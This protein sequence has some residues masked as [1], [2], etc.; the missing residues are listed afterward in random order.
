VISKKVR[1]VSLWVLGSLLTTTALAS[2]KVTE[3]ADEIRYDIQ[4]DK[5]SLSKAMIENQEFE[6]A[7]LM[8]VEGHEGILYKEGF[9]EV[10]VVRLLV[11]GIPEVQS[12]AVGKAVLRL[13]KPLMPSQPS[14]PKIQGAK[15][16][17]TLNRAVYKSNVAWPR[18]EYSVEQAGSV[19]GQKQYLLT[20][21]PFSY[22]PAIQTYQLRKHY[23]VIVKKTD[24]AENSKV[25]APEGIVFVV[26][27][28]FASSP[29]LARYAQLK[30]SL[31]FHVDY[32]VVGRDAQTPEEIRA[33]LQELYAR[34]SVKLSYAIL[35]GDA[36]DVPSKNATNISGVTDH[37]YSAIDTADYETDINGPDIGVGRISAIDEAQLAS[38]LDKYTRYQRGVF[39]N[40]EWLNGGAFLATDDRYQVAEGTHNYAIENYTA[41]AGYVGIFPQAR[42]LG[43]DQLYAITHHVPNETVQSAL[44]QGRTLIDYSGH[45]ATTFWAGP[46][47]SQ[48]NVRAIQNPDALP[49]VISNACI[50]GQFTVDES[51][52]ETWQRHPQ[53]AI[54]F[55]GSMDST[56]WDE[57]DI[58]ERRMFDTIYRDGE[59]VFSQITDKSL[60][61]VWQFYGGEGRSKYYWETYH[62]F[63]D[64]SIRYR[65]HATESLR[66]EGP[67]AL[68]FGVNQV[69]YRILNSA[70]APIKGARAA[71]A[72][73]DGSF[74]QSAYSDENGRVDFILSESVIPGTKVEVSVEANNSRI[75]KAE[76]LVVT[77][78]S[79]YVTLRNVKVNGR[80]ENAVYV[81]ETAAINFQ[82]RNLG[83]RATRGGTI[84][85]TSVEGPATIAGN[86]V[87]FG[88]IDSNRDTESEVV[89]LGITVG[90]GA[91][92]FEPIQVHYHWRTV[93]GAEGDTVQSLVVAKGV[94]AVTKLDF[95]T[96]NT[97]DGEGIRAGETGSV[98]VTIKNIGNET[99]AGGTLEAIAGS[100]VASVQGS[101]LEV[102]QLAPGASARI[103]VAL[104]VT[105]ATN[106]ANGS[107]A[108]LILRGSYDSIAQRVAL[109]GEG[110]F[111]V[112]VLGRV[113]I[114]ANNLNLT[115]PDNAPALS[116]TLKIEKAGSVTDVGLTVN[117]TH[118]YVSDLV[119]S[120]V[121]PDGTVVELRRN[122]GGGTPNVNET[123][124][125]DGL[126]R[127]A[128]NALL[129]KEISGEWKVLVQDNAD[130]DIGTLNSL[131]LTVKGYQ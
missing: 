20:L 118:P 5:I 2:V 126:A 106:A 109:Q 111:T 127:P 19:R 60:A 122:A 96:E 120:L 85:I 33:K 110:G 56:Y 58:L 107:C 34:N 87:N 8:G 128:L 74:T 124:G 27:A 50:T 13:V 45:G 76:L 7:K 82:L 70:G 83:G 17:F 1:A 14:M 97:T 54:V 116:Q 61:A 130:R 121:H 113:S 78:D 28:K 103:A 18:G 114:E 71:L 65:S 79:P 40:E 62:L 81:N 15:V 131:K 43:G 39:R 108:T 95:G 119:I 91:T 12:G 29:S 92:A 46:H 72:T 24:L 115:I 89:G 112:G 75:E 59:H 80:S 23:T 77:A 41:P 68:P 52:G 3:S 66:I 101:T 63:G 37:Y 55:W 11:N 64:P 102:P 49:F 84:E 44:R 9:P 90:S 86:T 51:F 26:G 104:S 73:E 105:V 10:P 123:Y 69:T 94:L 99:I 22:N 42:T 16:P 25:S 32:L 117:I 93:E 47:V 88:A 30:A 98:Y 129:G 35:V 6:K 100:L 4:I 21:H 38:I 31:G 48:E 67:R 53:G 125:L 57:D 36:E